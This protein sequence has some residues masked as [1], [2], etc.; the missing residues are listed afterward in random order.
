MSTVF[1]YIDV[2]TVC[3]CAFVCVLRVSAKLKIM[4]TVLAFELPIFSRKTLF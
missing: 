1:D 4:K 2:L 3:V